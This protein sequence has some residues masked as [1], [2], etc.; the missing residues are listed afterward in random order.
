[1]TTPRTLLALLP[2]L[3][4][5]CAPDGGP[6][7]DGEPGGYARLEVVG[8]ATV[9]VEAGSAVEIGFRYLD[10]SDEVVPG[11]VV[12]FAIAGDAMGGSLAAMSAST[13]GEGIAMATVRTG[14]DG[15]FDIVASSGAAEPASARVEV[16]PMTYGT[17]GIDVSYMGTRPLSSAELALFVNTRCED[18]ARS[19]P[20][21]ETVQSIAIGGRT[22]IGGLAL[23]VPMAV[24]VLGIDRANIV[25]AETCAD[26]T[27]IEPQQDLHVRLSDTAVAIRGPYATIETFDVTDGFSPEIDTI[28]EV[29]AGIAS[30]DPALWLVDMVAANPS[31]PGWLR[32]ALG[33]SF[34]RGLA[35]D[36]LRDGLSGFRL[37]SEAAELARFGADIDA[38]FRALQLRGELDFAS[39]DEYG[40]AQGRHHI[41]QL[42]VPLSDG[43]SVR[44]VDA[45][46]DTVITFGERIEM[47]EHALPI[48]LGQVV[49]VILYESILSRMS[50]GHST[51]GE[52]VTSVFDC[53]AIAM[54]IGTG[55]TAT[56]AR[57][58]C[59]VGVSMLEARIDEAIL[60]LFDYDTLNLSGS[61]A[62]VDADHDYD[63]ETI[64]SGEADARWTG[65]T[66]E[67]DFS[68]TFE[69]R[70][71][72]DPASTHRIRE[73][74]SGLH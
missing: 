25:A 12:D 44:F 29:S 34:T 15:A 74:M 66:G 35:A 55:T 5:A 18:L 45:S 42:R 61:A 69:G 48:N 67:L 37:P 72:D 46:A 73:R 38:A 21:P 49:E 28:L 20:N 63:L 62:L 33:S 39:P 64:G 23:D 43:E 68:G 31:A 16:R 56:I 58:A 13:D 30:A 32:T 40:V 57:G 60:G 3:L 24:Y 14:G 11:A 71:S 1:M 51:L 70:S 9:Q 4:L 47:D 10:A 17:L 41:S 52:L 2:L 54:R 50:G 27:M 8:A 6:R 26:V 59:T 53:D 22:Q 19:V 36:L 7:H 65:D